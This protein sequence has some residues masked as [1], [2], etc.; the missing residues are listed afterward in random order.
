MRKLPS[1]NPPNPENFWK[2][3]KFLK[4]GC[5]EWTGGFMGEKKLYGSLCFNNKT[6]HSHRFAYEYLIGEIPK[7]KELDHLCRNTKCANPEHLEP[8]SHKENCMRGL[9]GVSTGKKQKS[10]THCPHG[11]PYDKENTYIDSDGSRRC[12]ACNR[13]RGRERLRKERMMLN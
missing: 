4:N 10:K 8:V 7:G 9:T 5:W 2:H 12:N 13:E 1:N 11:H 6:N 3:V